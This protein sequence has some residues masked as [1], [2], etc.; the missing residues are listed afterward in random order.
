M[1]ILPDMI[2]DFSRDLYAPKLL[3]MV[4][5]NSAGDFDLLSGLWE[6]DRSE[7]SD[8]RDRIAALMGL[9]APRQRFQVNYGTED[10]RQTY[11]RLVTKLINKKPEPAWVILLHLFAFGPADAKLSLAGKTFS[12]PSWVPDWSGQRRSRLLPH[13][14]RKFTVSDGGPQA[15]AIQEVKGHPIREYDFVLH[16]KIRQRY[17]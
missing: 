10:W 2:D 1:R 15:E 7:C 16:S 4:I 13:D 17:L 3:Q 11:Q 12:F 5:G 8:P 14:R 6:L 9:D